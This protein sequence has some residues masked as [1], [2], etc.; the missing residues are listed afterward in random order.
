LTVYR[1]EIQRRFSDLDL[2]GH[3]NNVVFAEY[4]QEARVLMFRELFHGQASGVAWVLARQ[5]IDFRR[6]VMLRPEPLLVESRITEIG[7][8]S[9]RF[10]SCMID[11]TGAVAADAA[12]VMVCFDKETQ[13]GIPIPDSVREVL[14]R[15]IEE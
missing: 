13:Q 15:A 14:Q 7:R 10:T 3:V 4:A 9:F 6:P 8:S 11:E 12:G 5:E 1:A 2:M